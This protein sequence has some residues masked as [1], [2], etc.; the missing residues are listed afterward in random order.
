MSTEQSQPNVSAESAAGELQGYV[1]RTETGD[2]YA[3]PLPELE[4]FRLS[5]EQS[6]ALQAV[7]SNGGEVSG[8]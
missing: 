1:L 6:T 3:I 4:R 7:S 8:Y 5:A 2:V